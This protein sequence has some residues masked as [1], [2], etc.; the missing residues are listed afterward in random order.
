MQRQPR[1][2][3]T[4]SNFTHSHRRFILPPRP[5]A[6]V[7]RG[8]RVFLCPPHFLFFFLPLFPF[9]LQDKLNPTAAAGGAY[10]FNTELCDIDKTAQS[11]LFA[12]WRWDQIW[13][14]PHR[15]WTWT[16]THPDTQI[17]RSGSIII[18]VSF[19]FL[20]YYYLFFPSRL[21]QG[22]IEEIPYVSVE[23]SQLYVVITGVL[24]IW[25]EKERV[26]FRVCLLARPSSNCLC[27]CCP[28]LPS[29][30]PLSCREQD[31]RLALEGNAKCVSEP[32]GVQ[33]R[34]QTSTGQPVPC[35]HSETGG[36]FW[37]DLLSQRP[38]SKGHIRVHFSSKPNVYKDIPV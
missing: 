33:G 38:Q 21:S 30:S 14:I 3:P 6:T 31:R 22:Q 23:S 37:W 18:S 25:C 8:C 5:H 19:P 10:N 26:T 36:H 24:D 4:K 12:L 15:K 16:S 9:H 1:G 17:G 34:R 35:H 2:P 32:A 11:A 27:P 29:L 13:V 20:F 28:P 7:T